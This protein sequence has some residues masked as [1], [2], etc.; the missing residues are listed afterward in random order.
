MLDP[1]Q[2]PDPDGINPDAQPCFKAYVKG[3]EHSQP[4]GRNSVVEQSL[5]KNF[6]VLACIGNTLSSFKN[7]VYTGRSISLN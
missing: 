5:L 1:D 4:K 6:C 7:T 2:D 3:K